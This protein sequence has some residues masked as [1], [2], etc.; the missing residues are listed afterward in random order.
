MAT[1][2]CSQKDEVE[3]LVLEQ[4]YAF[5]QTAA[6]NDR[7]IF[8]YHLRHYKIMTIYSQPDRSARRTFRE[9]EPENALA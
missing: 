9:I 4:I 7:D 3:Q 1:T 5:K 2:S 8:E 6:M